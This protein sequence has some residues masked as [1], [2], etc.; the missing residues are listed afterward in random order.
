MY[1]NRASTKI[2]TSAWDCDKDNL[3]CSF[4]SPFNFSRAGDSWTVAINLGTGDWT[5]GRDRFLW[6]LTVEDRRECLVDSD[7]DRYPSEFCSRCCWW[8]WPGLIDAVVLQAIL[9]SFGTCGWYCG[10]CWYC[11]CPF[12]SL[13]ILSS[14]FSKV[15]HLPWAFSSWC[16]NSVKKAKQL[17]DQDLQKFYLWSKRSKSKM[18][19]SI[20]NISTF[21]LWVSFCGVMTS[22]RRWGVIKFL[23]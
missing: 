8:F 11:C 7:G 22:Q 17:F 4:S 5:A 12:I 6:S 16:S 3:T 2:H 14:C 13:R 10:W 23:L 21:A 18:H 9:W 15:K 1:N 19:K 20:S